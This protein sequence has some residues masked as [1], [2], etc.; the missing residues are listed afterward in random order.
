MEMTILDNGNI[1]YKTEYVTYLYIKEST[2]DTNNND[3]SLSGQI[4]SKY[5]DLKSKEGYI[6]TDGEQREILMYGYFEN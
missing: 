1:E 5:P 2:A 6:C 4:Y 3:N